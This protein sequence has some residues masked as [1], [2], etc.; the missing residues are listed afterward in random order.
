MHY[1]HHLLRS[2]FCKTQ[3]C[4]LMSWHH[5]ALLQLI[6]SK[7]ISLVKPN[8]LMS[9][10]TTFSHVFLCLPFD[11]T[12]PTS[13]LMHFFSHSSLSFFS[14]CPNHR[15]HPLLNTSSMSQSPTASSV[16]HLFS[17]PL[18]QSHHLH[19]CPLHA[20]HIL[21]SHSPCFTALTTLGET[22]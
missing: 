6:L 14:T 10:L 13:I 19:L 21:P 15:S 16:P 17:S 1:H 2:G 8:S 12:P 11:L 9:P 18:Y 4:S 20:L 22:P 7:A 3:M 5:A